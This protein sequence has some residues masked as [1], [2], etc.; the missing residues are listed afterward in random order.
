M[1]KLT[2]N[3]ARFNDLTKKVERKIA[4]ILPRGYNIKGGVIP[5]LQLPN[6]GRVTRNRIE[7]IE[8]LLKGDNVYTKLEY[9]LPTG[10]KLSGPK[11]RAYERSESS[12]KGALTR[13]RNKQRKKYPP[14]G[15][16]DPIGGRGYDDVIIDN[17]LSELAR[18]Y[19]RGKL[20][21]YFYAT[22]DYLNELITKYGKSSIARAI[23]NM[24]YT[25]AGYIQEEGFSYEAG[26]KY[27]AQAESM[28][29][30]QPV[31]EIENRL[32]GENIESD[33]EV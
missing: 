5:E 21:Q 16:P 3:K 9:T 30:G 20:I 8:N 24:P 25:L 2:P 12:R 29:T 11:G 23:Q 4:R 1:A 26:I 6:S 31:E 32:F 15:D 27:L 7:K 22:E 19:K 18:L 17:F 10:E 28:I 13:K 14:L 33:F